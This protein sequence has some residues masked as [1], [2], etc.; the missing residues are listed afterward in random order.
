MSRPL[1]SLIRAALAVLTSERL[2][3]ARR[4]RKATN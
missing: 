3:I 2:G 1:A 4:R